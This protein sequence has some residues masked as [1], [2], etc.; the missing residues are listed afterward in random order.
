MCASEAGVCEN[1]KQGGSWAR[2]GRREKRKI[3]GWGSEEM[4][5]E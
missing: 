2:K 5:R 4:K 3:C 1:D